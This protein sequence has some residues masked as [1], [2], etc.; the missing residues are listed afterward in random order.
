MTDF[1]GHF[2]VD[3]DDSD[4]LQIIVFG[5]TDIEKACSDLK[6]TAAPGPAFLL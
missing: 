2:K 3:G 1:G 4:S 6:S 5:P